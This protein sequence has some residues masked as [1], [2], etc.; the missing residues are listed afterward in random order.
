MSDFGDQ[1]FP[2]SPP[3][4]PPP[5]GGGPFPPQAPPPPPPPGAY[6][7]ASAPPAPPTY[8]APGTP[9]PYGPQSAFGQQQYA[10]M[11]K[12]R[13]AVPVGAGLLVVGGAMAAIGSFLNWFS[14]LGIDIT[15]FSN[16]GSDDVKDGPFFL[17][18]G[19]ILVG[20]GIALFSAKKVLAVTIIA[21]I[22][23]AFTVIF[24]LADLGDVSDLK[25]QA[26][27]ADIGF[28][29]GPGLYLCVFGGLIALAGAI[30]A[31]A[32]RRK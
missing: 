20:F 29:T 30:V 25:D 3:P 19:I 23:A 26:K 22:V 24:A 18:F 2:R 27:A 14:L 4:P 11:R 5:P 12:P 1:S 16:S 13:P 7:A 17:T 31:T 9:S 15:G 10:A 6:G 32:T 21:I 28:S 8:G